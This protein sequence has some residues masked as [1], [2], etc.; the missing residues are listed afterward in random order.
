MGNGRAAC[1]GLGFGF[2]EP[3]MNAMGA[4]RNGSG[5]CPLTRAEILRTR[6]GNRLAGSA[7]CVVVR[8]CKLACEIARPHRPGVASRSAPLLLF[9]Q[10]RRK[11]PLGFSDQCPLVVKLLVL[12]VL[13][14][15][16]DSRDSRAS[17]AVFGFSERHTRYF[18][19]AT[20]AALSRGR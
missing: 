11:A 18:S 1:G 2:F 10:Y 6:G 15:R 17:S 12:E 9:W 13:N 4:G 3:L 8:L 7:L 16:G 5:R 19:L 14:I 20:S